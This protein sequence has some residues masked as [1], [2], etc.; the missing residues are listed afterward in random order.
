MIFTRNH[1]RRD[2][3]RDPGD[4]DEQTGGEIVGDDVVGDVAPENHLKPGQTVVPERA[5]DE[6]FVLIVQRGNLNVVVQHDT[7]E[8]RERLNM[9]LVLGT[10]WGTD[11]RLSSSENKQKT[12][13]VKQKTKNKS[14]IF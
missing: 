12:I 14:I 9:G 5:A 3:E 13:R 2:E 10:E 11:G 8:L 7:P 4:H 6:N 1:I